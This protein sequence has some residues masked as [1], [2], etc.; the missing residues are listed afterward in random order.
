MPEQVNFT[1]SS[2]LMQDYEIVAIAEQ[3]VR[4]GVTKIRL[5]GGEPL[6]RKDAKKIISQLS[7]L[8]VELTLTTNAYLIDEYLDTIRDAGIHSLNVSLDTLNRNRFLAITKR[9][10]FNKIWNNILLL[11]KAGFHVKLNMVVMKG[12]NDD[13]LESFVALTK[14]MPIHV[15]F[16]EFM[17]FDGNQWNKDLVYPYQQMI[18][19]ITSAFDIIKLYDAYADTAKKFQVIG[20][21]GTFAMITTMTMPFCDECNRIRLTSDGKIKNCLFS[22]EETDLLTA[23]RKGECIEDLIR[24]N[25][26]KKHRRLGGQLSPDFQEIDTNQLVN[27]SMVKI[28]G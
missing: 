23:Y 25:I 8:P 28:G 19:R 20:Y 22:K 17:P 13:E 18:D 3:F 21:Q 4:L 10:H 15:R 1:P 27:R 16:I 7:K 6:V 11:I 2:L 24:N 9:D 26:M 12:I 14:D 5:T